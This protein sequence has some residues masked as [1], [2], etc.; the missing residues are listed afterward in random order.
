[1]ITNVLLSA[2][3]AMELLL[4][5][6]LWIVI[7]RLKRLDGLHNLLTGKPANVAD[8]RRWKPL[9]ERLIG[10]MAARNGKGNGLERGKDYL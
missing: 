2:V 4:A 6:L 10:I 9:G 1:M 5:V 8:N 7:H 3:L